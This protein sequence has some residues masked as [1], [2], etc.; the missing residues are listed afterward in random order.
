M[1]VSL[2][3]KPDLHGFD[4]S[5][6]PIWVFDPKR[7]CMLYAN[8]S[9]LKLWRSPSLDEFLARDFSQASEA[10]KTRT[11]AILPRLAQGEVVRERNTFYPH[12]EPVSVDCLVSGLRHP[13][14]HVVILL[15]GSELQISPH[16]LRALE[17]LRH[18]S[19]PVTLYDGEGLPVFRNPA[20][21]ALY[22]G[23]GR[24]F[25]T[26]LSDPTEAEPLWREMLASS[27]IDGRC[28]TVVSM[29]TAAGP[30][31]HVLDARTTRDPVNGSICVLV[32]EQDVTADVE[33][34][35]RIEH[36][37]SHDPLTDLAN[38]SLLRARLEAALT[39][40][41]ASHSVALLLLDLDQFKMINDMHG[42]GAGD[43]L[44]CLVAQRLRACVGRAS[45]FV[46]R[47]GGD[48]FAILLTTSN[49]SLVADCMAS[50]IISDLGEPFDLDGK[51][52]QIGISIGIAFAGLSSTSTSLLRNADL[53]LYRAKGEGRNT[54]RFFNEAGDDERSRAGFVPTRLSTSGSAAVIA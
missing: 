5:R 30:R 12:G 7:L 39:C 29:Q 2:D 37:A 50:K 14:E 20:A 4:L 22:S 41:N 21:L 43:D 45:G 26:C 13:D 11:L 54:Y 35:A 25:S 24:R 36:M 51:P 34:R 15:E 52:C 38:R 27:D 10:M 40:P 31:W 44:L 16:E 9:A 17:A 32:N 42:H 19:A 49:P 1:P 18:L 53:A 3:G 23:D 47:L 48:E 46:A 33:A 28:C 8:S 6:H